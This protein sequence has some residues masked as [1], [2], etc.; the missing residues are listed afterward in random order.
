MKQDV[1]FLEGI[2]EADETYVG[3]RNKFRNPSLDTP[4][5]GLI[6]RGGFL[7]AVVAP[8]GN[9]AIIE[10]LKSKVRI[11]STVMTDKLRIYRESRRHGFKHKSVNHGIREY[12]RGHVHTNTIENFWGQFKRSIRGTHHSVSKK[13]LQL[14][15]DEFVFRRNNRDHNDAFTKMIARV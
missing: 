10:N 9:E 3:G 8:R 12:V 5:L 4:V 7:S 6:E 13:H 2:V 14:Y 11:G 1:R 15:V